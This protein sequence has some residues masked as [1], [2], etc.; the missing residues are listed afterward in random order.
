MGNI[1]RLS[2]GQ[3]DSPG[4]ETW[5]QSGCEGWRPKDWR[6]LSAFPQTEE[7]NSGE[8]PPNYKGTSV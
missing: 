4:P 5:G 1:T 6:S 8:R 3:A 7:G 2:P